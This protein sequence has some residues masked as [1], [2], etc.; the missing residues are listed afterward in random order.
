MQLNQAGKL[1]VA[2][3]NGLVAGVLAGNLG[4]GITLFGVTVAVL[5]QTKKS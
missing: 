1:V 2:V 4:L 3:L 5:C